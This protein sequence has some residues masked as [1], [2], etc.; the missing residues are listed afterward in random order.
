MSNFLFEGD[1]KRKPVQNLGGRSRHT[2]GRDTILH[3]AQMERE[4]RE[5]FDTVN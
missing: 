2:E 3:N 1:Y 5:V 4:K